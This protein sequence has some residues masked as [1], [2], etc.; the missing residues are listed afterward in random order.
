MNLVV[1]RLDRVIVASV[2]GEPRL[3][4]EFGVV[5]GVGE[6]IVD[7]VP[8]RQATVVELLGNQDI[9]A[10]RISAVAGWI[11]KGISPT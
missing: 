9:S 4:A 2:T 1:N 6:Q 8:E 11:A 10:R 3:V 7:T 5:A